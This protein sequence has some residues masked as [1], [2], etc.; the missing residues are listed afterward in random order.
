MF[1]K[2]IVTIAI[3]FIL[4]TDRA[5]NSQREEHHKDD[6][7]FA[8]KHIWTRYTP[9]NENIAWKMC[10]I[11]SETRLILKDAQPYWNILK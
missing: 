6:N 4:E 5:I 7:S 9:S 3:V 2:E 11:M 1:I 10:R 8:Y